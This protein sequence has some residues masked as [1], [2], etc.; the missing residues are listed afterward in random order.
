[1]DEAVIQLGLV[2]L[3]GF[4][5]PIVPVFP[6]RLALLIPVVAATVNPL[7]VVF[8]ASVG[9]S[10]GTLPLYAVTRE[11]NDLATVKRWL[12]HHWM[13]KLVSALEG[14]MFAC[15]LLFALLP[16][17]DQLMSVMSGFKGYPAWKMTLGFFIGRLPYYALLAFFGVRFS[18]TINGVSRVLFTAFGM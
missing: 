15:I 14:R 4:I 3:V 16:L 12:S 7:L 11:A 10:V 6:I 9:S 1:M 13:R 8:A 17:P 2:A 18:E 5:L